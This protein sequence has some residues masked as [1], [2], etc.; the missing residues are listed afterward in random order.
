MPQPEIRI[1]VLPDTGDERG[2]SFQTGPEWIEFLGTVDDAHIATILPGHVRGNHYHKR[3][4][5]V[6][7]VLHADTWEM[8]WDRGE[9]TAVKV[10]KF[11]GSGAVILEVEP[12]AAHALANTGNAPLWIMG[13]SNG[14]W[15]AN[16][17][18]AFARKLLPRPE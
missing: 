17:P 7:A 18:D 4:R 8:A 3:R 13:L 6:I 5:E 2:S 15:D 16:A 12:L 9:D 14:E 1:S 10:E 11:S